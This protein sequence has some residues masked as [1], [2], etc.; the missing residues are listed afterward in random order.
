MHWRSGLQW[1]EQA[2]L[3]LFKVVVVEVVAVLRCSTAG[4]HRPDPGQQ[5]CCR[6]FGWRRG[7]WC[8]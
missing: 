7:R 5:A 8:R 1:S 4:R 3:R 2:W 6:T